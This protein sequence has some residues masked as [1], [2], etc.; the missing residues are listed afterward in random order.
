MLVFGN[1]SEDWSLESAFTFY[2]YET[3]ADIYTLALNDALRADHGFSM[4]SRIV[5]DM[6][7]LVSNFDEAQ[8]RLFLSF[9]TGS[10]RLPVGG[11]P[12][13]VSL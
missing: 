6:L 1:S 11:G 13:P 9:S 8:R 4:D 7:S 12:S 10:P 2:K 5:R 3:A